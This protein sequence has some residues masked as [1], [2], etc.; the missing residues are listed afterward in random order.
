MDIRAA[1]LAYAPYN[2]QE[3]LDKALILRAI[4]IFPDL[5]NRE[6]T[7][8]HMTASNWITNPTRDRILMVHHNIYN[9]WAWTGGH[10]DGESDL[11]AVALREAKEETGL[12]ELTP[13]YDGV[14]S[15]QCLAVHHHIKRGVYVPSHLHLDFCY[16]WQADDRA[17][18]HAKQDENS[19]VRWVPID[20][21]QRWSGEDDME[22][23]YSKLNAKLKALPQRQKN[24]ISERKNGNK[25]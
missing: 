25:S 24:F 23:V 22:M 7:I 5:L 15:I 21:V 16:L 10:A 6:N 1:L 14:F 18:V 11:R 13:L 20:D 9:A 8:C 12:T 4:E 17:A 2:E 3:T 19:G